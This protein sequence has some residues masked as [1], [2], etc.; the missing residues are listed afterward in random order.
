MDTTQWRPDDAR[1]H[2][3]VSYVRDI[4]DDEIPLS[5][6][7]T[8]KRQVPPNPK[9]VVFYIIK[10]HTS[11]SVER[12]YS[13]FAW[14]RA[15]FNH[16][17][18]GM[19]LP[20]MPKKELIATDSTVSGRVAGL[21]NFLRGVLHNPYLRDDAL[22]SRFLRAEADDWL[23]LRSAS[24]EVMGRDESLRSSGARRWRVLVD[25]FELPEGQPTVPL[26]TSLRS[27]AEQLMR[28]TA[29]A[30][31]ASDAMRPQLDLLLRQWQVVA[32]LVQGGHALATEK[33][34][35]LKYLPDVK[36]AAVSMKGDQLARSLGRLPGVLRGEADGLELL[37]AT[38]REDADYIQSFMEVRS[39]VRGTGGGIVGGSV[40]GI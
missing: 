37:A 23:A 7:G 21:E 14:L 19:L 30:A 5:I 40:G 17:Y 25:S 35:V 36:D 10:S 39:C 1:F 28:V 18:G 4:E 2:D 16:H 22:L 26:I 6:A 27:E 12:R 32:D 15:M 3:E 34:Y 20:P 8:S 33:K 29:A 13:D 9:P 38:M 24:P 31:A 11:N